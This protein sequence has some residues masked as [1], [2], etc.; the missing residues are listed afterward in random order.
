MNVQKNKQNALHKACGKCAL[1]IAVVF[2]SACS[3]IPRGL[4]QSDIYSVS[5][6]K[7]N[8]ML[9]EFIERSIINQ[10]REFN[11]EKNTLIKKELDSLLSLF[12]CRVFGAHLCAVCRLVY[13][14]PRQNFGKKNA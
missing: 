4:K 2:L 7:D 1:C 11:S 13:T 9:V 6:K 12:R 5:A 14:E 3:T 10:Y 8:R